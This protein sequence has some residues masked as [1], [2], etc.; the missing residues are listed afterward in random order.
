VLGVVVVVLG[1]EVVGVGVGEPA[2]GWQF[3]GVPVDGAGQVVDR[4]VPGGG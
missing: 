1:V 4:V 3:G 2:G